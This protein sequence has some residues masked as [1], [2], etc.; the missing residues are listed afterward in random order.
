MNKRSRL[1]QQSLIRAGASTRANIQIIIEK[2]IASQDS[3]AFRAAAAIVA[4]LLS[5]DPHIYAITIA[6]QLRA[7]LIF[8]TQA[9]AEAWLESIGAH[10]IDNGGWVDEDD[11]YYEILEIIPR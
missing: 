2:G 3:A 11:S 5:E 1:D 9:A 8:G 7:N 10:E 6:S 4:H